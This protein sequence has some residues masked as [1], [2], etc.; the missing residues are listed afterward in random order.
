LRY[1]ISR[2]T[3]FVTLGDELRHIKN[4]MNIQTQRFGDKIEIEYLVDE[5][6]F[7]YKIIKLI[8]Q[9]LVENAIFHG[10]ETKRGKGR[11]LISAYKDADSIY[12]NIVDDG[13]G[14]D[15]EKLEVLNAVFQGLVDLEHSDV[16]S[17]K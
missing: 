11:I 12:I 1:S 7:K 17:N 10:L 14:V 3:E 15:P 8:L 16:G 13:L 6:L 9:P 2:N 5:E 4:Y